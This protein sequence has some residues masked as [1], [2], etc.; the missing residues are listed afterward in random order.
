MRQLL[1]TSGAAGES[2]ELLDVASDLVFADTA[3]RARPLVCAVL[4]HAYG[5]HGRPLRVLAASVE[6]VHAASLL[7]DDVVDE[8]PLRR[9]RP[10]A[11]ARFGSGMAVLS[12]DLVLCRALGAMSRLGPGLVECA[13]DTVEAMS[14]AALA[15]L[16]ARRDFT[17]DRARWT[18]I[19][20]GKTA[21]LFGL[22]GE[23]VGRLAG[24][25][26]LGRTLKGALVELGLAFQILD[27]VGDFG[28][29]NSK[30]RFQDLR[31]GNPSFPIVLTCEADDDFR[32]SLAHEWEGG[33]PSEQTLSE[34]AVRVASSGALARA[35]DVA[36]AHVRE[37]R[38][39][40]GD[41]TARLGDL[42]RWAE[43][44][45]GPVPLDE[46]GGEAA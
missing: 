8:S 24:R 27:D 9:G 7:H 18:E 6:L 40:L 45:A 20:H 42:F 46:T 28:S 17:V 26:E 43:A 35:I 30:P 25:E 33:A 3:K 16:D 32:S 13:I 12:G 19:A 31:E 10:T 22:C 21:V 14:G 4:G 38:C 44:L 29:G 37:A 39:L 23:G 15:E 36:K 1:D 5:V 11:N 2:L 34:L 41:E